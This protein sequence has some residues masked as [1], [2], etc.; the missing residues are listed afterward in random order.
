MA[1]AGIT[2]VEQPEPEVGQLAGRF[3]PQAR[4]RVQDYLASFRS[5]DPVLVLLYG[6][7]N[8][9]EPGTWSMQAISTD[10]LCEM[11]RM[12][13]SFGGIVCY[14]L[15]GVRV[16]VPQLAHIAELNRGVLSFSGN[17]LV[18]TLVEQAPA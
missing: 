17:R 11:S 8:G 5:F 18:A 15:D 6:N 10:M 12:Y 1:E 4:R 13:A 3:S 9:T 16:V 2:A 7:S 14:E